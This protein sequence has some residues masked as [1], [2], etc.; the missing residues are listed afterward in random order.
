I[1]LR[2]GNRVSVFQGDG[3]TSD[4]FAPV[5]V[6][7]LDML[8][9]PSGLSGVIA[10]LD[11][12]KRKNIGTLPDTDIV[13]LGLYADNNS[14]GNLGSFDPEI[15]QGGAPV[16]TYIASATFNNGDLSWNFTNL[17]AL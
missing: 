6:M 11:S 1:Q 13:E 15:F 8:L 10:K 12:I 14:Q 2:Y 3:I 7:R 9:Q 16:D 5:P 4:K 17:N